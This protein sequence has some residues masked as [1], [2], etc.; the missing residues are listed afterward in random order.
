MPF[1]DLINHRCGTRTLLVR[2]K[3]GA[4]RLHAGCAYKRGQQLFVSYGERDWWG[5]GLGLGIECG[6][7]LGRA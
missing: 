3:Q 6:C 1:Y 4:W 7:G 5:P 2:T